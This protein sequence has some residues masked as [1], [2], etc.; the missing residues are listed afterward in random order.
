MDL[1]TAITSINWFSVVIAA[2]STFLVGGLWYGPLFGKAWMSEFGFSEDDLKGR[3]A[4]KTFGLSLILAF[5]ASAILE[6]FIGSEADVVYGTMADSL[7]AL[8]GSP[9]FWEY[10]IYSKCKP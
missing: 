2:V 1:A 5:V 6:M 8:D 4:P 7:P 9:P 10:C 3:S